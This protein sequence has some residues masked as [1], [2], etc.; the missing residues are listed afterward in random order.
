MTDVE[1]AIDMTQEEE[2]NDHEF[3][4]THMRYVCIV[5]F[6]FATSAGIS[7]FAFDVYEGHRA[8]MEV[9]FA[10][11]FVDVT[12]PTMLEACG[13][14]TLSCATLMFFIVAHLNCY[15]VFYLV[16][17]MFS[18][19]V[20]NLA[21]SVWGL[22]VGMDKFP[23]M[24]SL[25]SSFGFYTSI[26][27]L[28][29]NNVE[30]FTLSDYITKLD[31]AE[32]APYLYLVF[33]GGLKVTACFLVILEAQC[34]LEHT[35]AETKK[36]ILMERERDRRVNE[37]KLQELELERQLQLAKKN[38]DLMKA[39]AAM[40]HNG[41]RVLNETIFWMQKIESDIAPVMENQSGSLK[42]ACTKLLKI[43]RETKLRCRR[44]SKN[45][46]QVLMREAIGNNTYEPLQV[47]TCMRSHLELYSD[48]YVVVVVDSLVPQWILL[49]QGVFDIIA[50]NALS[51]ARVHG[52]N[53]GIV[54]IGCIVDCGRVVLTIRNQPGD[55]HTKA[56]RVMPTNSIECADA[57]KTSHLGNVDSTFLGLNEITDAVPYL[58]AGE[59]SLVF[60]ECEVIFTLSF[61]LA[62]VAAMGTH[63]T[64]M[65]LP[66]GTA[67]ICIDDDK[68]TRLQ[69][70]GL[71]RKLELDPEKCLVLGETFDEVKRAPEIVMQ[72][73]SRYKNVIVITDQNFDEYESGQEALGTDI[74]EELTAKGFNGLMFVRSGNDSVE[75]IKF[76]REKGACD[77][78]SKE[79]KVADLAVSVLLKYNE[80]RANN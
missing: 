28:E 79:S 78:L 52:K 47:V 75:D 65:P 30:I 16:R 73:A 54:H 74:L 20:M 1:I 60:N 29:V 76:Y 66:N 23:I 15:M 58:P 71:V 8:G 53:E 25:L 4:R 40:N 61:E 21:I 55:N 36:T 77:V 57:F 68:C 46:R 64:T 22:L 6:L 34:M 31:Y 45:C 26:R 5:L 43:A 24:C 56:R 13:V 14:I 17:G 35:A 3:R 38:D 50:G 51:N 70:K 63:P 62:E 18:T 48:A 41:K 44:A 42:A 59:V 67:V 19:Y 2:T 72:H 32:H 10:L 11:T 39:Y 80:A 69:Y 37:Y 33:Q 27:I 49:D 12:I 9:V 7:T